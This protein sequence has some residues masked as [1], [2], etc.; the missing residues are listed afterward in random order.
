MRPIDLTGIGLF[1]IAARWCIIQSNIISARLNHGSMV[2]VAPLTQNIPGISRDPEGILGF[3]RKFLRFL[4]DLA[5]S[6]G[7]PRESLESRGIPRDPAGFLGNPWDSGGTQR[8]PSGFSGIPAGFPQES[9]AFP[10]DSQGIPGIP[11]DPA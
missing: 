3:L 4:Q 10:R 6:H 9:L 11:R 1:A 8:D 2:S 7:I 5:G